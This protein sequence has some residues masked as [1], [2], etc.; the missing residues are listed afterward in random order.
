MPTART[1]APANRLDVVVELMHRGDFPAALTVAKKLTEDEAT[2][3]DALITMGNLYSLMG[4]PEQAR[5]AF[6]AALACEPL[7]VEARV[8]GGVA[9]L[10]VGDLREARAE[11]TKAL[12]LEPTLALGHYL[13]AQVQERLKEFEAAR[14]SYRNAIAQVRFPQRVLA[15]HYPDMPSSPETV[16][17]ASRYALAALEER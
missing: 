1:R 13:V 5:D 6:T 2:D 17:R 15:G 14:R 7:C 3:L 4:M 8:F 11:L 12:F 10:Q 9:A 16:A